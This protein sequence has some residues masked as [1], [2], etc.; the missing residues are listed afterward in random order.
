MAI[1]NGTPN[2]DTLAGTNL[3]DTINGFDGNDMITGGLGADTMYGGNGN[4]FLYGEA[5]RASRYGG[6]GN[7]T[8]YV[9]SAGD[10]V[11]EVKAD[12]KAFFKLLYHLLVD[13]ER[14]PRLPTLFAALGPERVR[15]LL[16]R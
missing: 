8:Y 10:K 14:G 9:D 7:D 16:A 1:I 11:D 5:G 15:A 3:A 6:A 4:D 12:Q 13:A 2:N